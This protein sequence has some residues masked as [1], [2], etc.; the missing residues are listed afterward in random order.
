MNIIVTDSYTLNPKDNSWD[1]ILALGKVVFYDKTEP[2]QLITRAKNADILIVNKTQVTGEAFDHLPKLKTIMMS[3]TGYDCVDIEA[4]GSKGIPVCNVPEYGTDSV[5]QHVMS[6]LLEISNRVGLH[7][8]AVKEGEWTA[9]KDWSFWKTDL[10]ELNGK[11]MGIVGFGKIGRRVGELAHAFG[12]K[13]VAHDRVKTIDPDYQ[14]FSWSSSIKDLFKTA[15]VITLHTPLTEELTGFVNS[16]ILRLVK[17]EAILINAARGGL[18]N[19]D[20][21]AMAL[22]DGWLKGAALDTVSI[23]PIRANNPLL[24]AKNTLITPHIAWATKEA[25]QRM[26]KK[27]AENIKAFLNGSPQNVINTSCLNSPKK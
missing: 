23:E 24:Q 13:I 22:N 20:D 15:D 6:L 8:I 7:D 18:V 12:M 9:A 3:A 14:P 27:V 5:A 21:L 16:T 11:I 19:E 25:R 4:A 10:F 26:I 1:S 2:E 17:P